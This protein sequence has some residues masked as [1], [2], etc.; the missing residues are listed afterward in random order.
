MLV[1]HVQDPGFNLWH[2]G[3]KKN[4]TGFLVPPLEVQIQ[5]VVVQIL[6]C[7]KLSDVTG[8]QTT[9]QEGPIPFYV[10]G[11]ESQGSGVSHKSRDQIQMMERSRRLGPHPGYTVHQ[12]RH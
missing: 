7:S 11:M 12:I 10:N 4:K 2:R 3:K 6:H 8:L 5:R 9:L 1:Y